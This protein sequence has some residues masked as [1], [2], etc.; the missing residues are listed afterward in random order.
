MATLFGN[1]SDSLEVPVPEDEPRATSGRTLAA[2]GSHA[3][4]PQRKQQ[5][6]E[7]PASMEEDPPATDS[8]KL[9]K[10]LAM[11]MEMK[12]GNVETNTTVKQ[13]QVY[14]NAVKT[15]RT[16]QKRRLKHH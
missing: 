11:V 1:T 15:R 4:S 12:T 7:D 13:I 10:L 2:Q 5:K 3:D 8:A 6:K 16:K 9:D 14:M